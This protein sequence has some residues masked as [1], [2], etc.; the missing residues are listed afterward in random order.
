MPLENNYG[1]ITK[2][3]ALI[4]GLFI[5]LFVLNKKEEYL[6]PLD[7]IYA[8]SQKQ[9]QQPKQ[10]DLSGN[11]YAPFN[12]VTF[13]NQLYGFYGGLCN[14]LYQKRY[15]YNPSPPTTNASKDLREQP[16]FTPE[17]PGKGFGIFSHTDILG[18]Y[19]DQRICQW[20]PDAVKNAQ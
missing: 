16:Y 17:T 13:S 14:H 15:M 20:A 12:D 11:T 1:D 10:K 6:N 2:G 4:S 3:I 19:R 18:N 5:M 9:T 8:V 7:D